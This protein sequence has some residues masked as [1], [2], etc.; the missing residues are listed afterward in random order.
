VRDGTAR[1]L[2]RLHTSVFRLT[3]GRLGKR[4]V[5]NDMLLLTTTGRITG[6]PHTVPLL[7]L[8][9]GDT[10]VVFASWG[11]RDVHPEWYL[12]LSSRPEVEVELAGGERRRMRART[13]DGDERERWWERAMAAYDGYAVYQGRTHRHIPVVLLEPRGTPDGGRP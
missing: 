7:F 12:N 10:L 8:R 4:L 6:R 2:S 3:G 5:A 1:R 13:V 11:G 9:D